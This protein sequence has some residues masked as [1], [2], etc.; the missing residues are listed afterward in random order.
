MS[1]VPLY[2]YMI[3][4]IQY[5]GRI[6]DDWDEALRIPDLLTRIVARCGPADTKSC[7]IRTC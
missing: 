2:R 6:T 1:E 5:G 4:E 3:A 7:A